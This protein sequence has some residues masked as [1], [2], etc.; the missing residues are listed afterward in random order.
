MKFLPVFLVA[1]LLPL[2]AAH[3]DETKPTPLGLYGQIRDLVLP[4]SELEARP[5]EQETPVVLRI[6]TVRPH[7]DS[8]R[9]DFDYYGLEGG[10]FDLRDFLQRID[11]GNTANLPPISVRFDTV[12][13][14]TRLKPNPPASAKLPKVGGYRNALIAGA[15]IWVLGMLALIFYKRPK[16]A[17]DPD[18]EAPPLSFADKLRPLL[19]SA[20]AGELDKDQQAQLERSLL[21]FWRNKLGLSDESPATALIKLRGHDEAG[22]LLRQLEAWLHAPQQEKPTDLDALLA[23]YRQ[24]AAPKS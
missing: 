10:E 13:D 3:A 8:F 20:S 2:L 9:Y 21:G 24:I 12:L 11:G 7:G 1:L 16:A 23:P 5:L 18:A 17:L 6:V 15:I 14:A 4:G 22:A 19:E